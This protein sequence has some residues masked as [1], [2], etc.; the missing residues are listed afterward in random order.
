MAFLASPGDVTEPKPV[1]SPSFP[2][3][4]TNS[5]SGWR[6]AYESSD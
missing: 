6:Y 5:V 1:L 3:A 2:A 4:T